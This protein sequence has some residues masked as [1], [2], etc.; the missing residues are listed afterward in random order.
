LT[1]NKYVE[2]RKKRLKEREERFRKERERIR[3][4]KEKEQALRLKKW[5][6][7]VARRREIEKQL[8]EK[9]RLEKERQEKAK[10]A[11]CG[12]KKTLEE[13]ESKASICA[14]E[15]MKKI[16]ELLM[17]ADQSFEF[18]DYEKTVVLSHEITEL[19][20]KARLEALKEAEPKEKRRAEGGK[21]FYCV[22]PCSEEKSFGQIGMNDEGVYTITYRDISAV[23][24]DSPITDY[25][26]TEDNVRRHEAVLRQL[27]ECHTVVPVEFGTTIK[28]EK[29]LERLLTKAYESTR[30]CLRLVDTMVELGVKVVL[31]GDIMFADPE[32]RKEN[33][34]DILGSLSA[35]AKQAVAGDLFSD[36]LILNTSFLVHRK[37]IE[38]FSNEVARLQG[39]YPMF[40]LLYSGP[41]PPHNFVYIKIGTE[42]MEISK[43]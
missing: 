4:L 34:S 25:E 7:L 40:K 28:N 30:E 16:N 23:V 35:I 5:S 14:S 26:M 37:D 8:L 20:E 10:A 39:K 41:W 29:I 33:A 19:L 18:K 1:K 32:K 6:D 42:G 13:T 17:D 24:S 9:T 36:R 3:Q 15:T 38:A 21:Y 27:M 2:L 43:R 11:L 22:M 12:V 31:N